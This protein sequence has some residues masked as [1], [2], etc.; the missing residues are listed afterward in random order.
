MDQINLF[1]ITRLVTLLCLIAY[2]PLWVIYCQS[3]ISSRTAVK[4]F[5][6]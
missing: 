1:E 2:Q 6:S 3:H 4:L 5:N